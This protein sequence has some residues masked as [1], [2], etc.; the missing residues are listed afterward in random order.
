[1]VPLLGRDPR[2]A[3]CRLSEVDDGDNHGPA[4]G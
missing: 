3:C 2:L 4:I 1:L